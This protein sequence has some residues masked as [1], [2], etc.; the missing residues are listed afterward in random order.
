MKISTAKAQEIRF[1]IM[2]GKNHNP[3]NMTLKE[4][5]DWSDE[6]LP[7]NACTAFQRTIRPLYSEEEV[8]ALYSIPIDEI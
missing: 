5:Q 6:Y 2:F 7:L 4:A 3:E 1:G 8:K